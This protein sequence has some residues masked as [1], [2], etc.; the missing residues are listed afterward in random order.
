MDRVGRPYGFQLSLARLALSARPPERASAWAANQIYR[1]HFI[2]TPAH[3]GRAR[4]AERLSREALGLAGARPAPPRLWVRDWSLDV[5]GA[6]ALL[7]SA[8]AEDAVLE[9][10]LEPAKAPI[11]GKDLDLFTEGP[12]EASV[13]LYLLPRLSADGHLTLD[14]ETLDVTGT[15]TLEHAWGALPTAQGQLALNRFGLELDDGRELYCIEIRRLDGS[16]TPIPS[17][18]LIGADGGVRSFRR[19]EIL[20]EPVQRWRSPRSGVEYPVG[21]TLTIRA[22]ELQLRLSPTVLDQELDLSA[23]LWSGAV[24]VSGEQSGTLVVGSGRIELTP[25]AQPGSA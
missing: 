21:W 14:G 22:L 10:R 11:S 4:K 17:C 20:L 19:R 23:R 3:G 15:A 1:A 24:S 18:A 25:V 13:Q 9:L 6:G 16:G 7:L 12:G 2:L 5:E 8:A